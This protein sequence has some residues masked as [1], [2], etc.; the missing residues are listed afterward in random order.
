MCLI[1]ANPSGL[2]VPDAYID[3]AYST[4]HDGFGIMWAKDNELK[5]KR[6]LFPRSQIHDI[7]EEFHA[8]ETPYVAHFRFA[9]HGKTTTNN[10]HPFPI[11]DDL[12]G[13]AMVHNGTLSGN[14]W[15]D[16]IR[17]DTSLLADKI[18]RHVLH[19]E[20]SSVDLFD[21]EIP[22]IRERYQASVGTDKLVFM[23]GLGDVNILNEKYGHWLDGVW[24][25]NQYSIKSI[26]TRASEAAKSV[27]KK[28]KKSGSWK[29]QTLDDSFD[30]EP[31]SFSIPRII[32]FP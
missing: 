20:F 18:K 13:I 6:G 16:S 8:Y 17:S 15:R 27:F 25:S 2:H 4:N 9:T 28:K 5:L 31:T 29:A 26:S 10:C 23:N 3:N 11:V 30:S 12:G 32:P 21:L 1:I 19:G 14:E 24:Y 7:L 22:V